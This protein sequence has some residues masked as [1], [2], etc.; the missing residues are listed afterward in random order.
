MV[1]NM[2]VSYMDWRMQVLEAP[3]GDLLACMEMAKVLVLCCWTKL[4]F[5]FWF[6]R[7]YISNFYSM[8]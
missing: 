1:L 3:H 2:K 4:F 6:P 7:L 5:F 8:Y